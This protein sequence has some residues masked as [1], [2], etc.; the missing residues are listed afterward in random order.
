M[1]GARARREP[2]DAWLFQTVAEAD[3]ARRGAWAALEAAYAQ[4]GPRSAAYRDARRAWLA[5]HSRWAAVWRAAWQVTYRR[6]CP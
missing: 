2:A 1:S 5:A 4:H 6:L 3:T